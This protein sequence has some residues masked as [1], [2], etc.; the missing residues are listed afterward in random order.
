MEALLLELAEQ[1]GY[2]EIGQV[3]ES[4]TYLPEY[5]LLK[6]MSGVNFSQPNTGRLPCSKLFFLLL[7][8]ACVFTN[9]VFAPFEEPV[10]F[11]E[12][13]V[14]PVHKTVI[15]ENDIPYWLL[16]IWD[17]TPSG[18][19]QYQRI[20]KAFQSLAG[21]ES[22]FD[23]S[24]K[25]SVQLSAGG[26]PSEIRTIDILVTDVTGTISMESQGSGLWEALVLSVFLDDS[27]GRVI[28]L[29]EPAANLHPNMQHRLVEDLY[30][31]PGQVFVVTHSAHLLPTR[32]DRLQHVYRFQK[33]AD[34]TR[35]FSGGPFLQVNSRELRINL[36]LPSMSPAYFSQ[37]GCCSW[38]GQLKTEHFLSGFP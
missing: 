26:S 12:K 10:P 2:L 18:K 29:D 13:K 30:D 36:P 33:E 4:Q 31:A 14:F 20:Q 19:E 15:D 38:K 8:N 37:M 34:R 23:M 25:T 9:S 6:E 5:V 24:V 27:T 7:R 1:H 17:G 11:D 32:A 3:T 28:L 21:E 35:I 16:G 22:T